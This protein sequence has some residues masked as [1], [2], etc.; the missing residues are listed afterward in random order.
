MKISYNWLLEYVDVKNSARAV[1]QWLTMAGLEVTSLE[2]KGK[3]SIL[4][5]EVTTN[6]PDWLSV[7][8]V[9]REVSAITGKR[10]KMPVVGNLTQAVRDKEIKVEVHDK[11]L[12]PR[13]TARIIDGVRVEPS[14]DWLRDRLQNIGVRPVNN[15]VDITNFVLF[16]MG[17]P[18][19]AFDYDK[20]AGQKVIVRRAQKGEAITTIDGVKREL[21]A[22]M[23]VIADEKGPVAV[24][25]V[26]GGLDTEVS[27]STKTIL[28][29]SACFDPISVRRAQK[30]LWLSSDSSYRFE[31]GVDL[32]GVL[33]A[34]NRA[35]GLTADI[36][37]GKIG[38]LKDIGTKVAKQNMVK[39]SIPR[40]NRILG[41]SLSPVA[42]KKIL[43]GLGLKVGAAQEELTVS[44]PSFRRDL[45]REEDLIEEIARIYGYDKIPT[46][47]PKTVGHLG[48]KEPA[49]KIQEAARAVLTG[50]GLDEIVTYSLVDKKDLENAGLLKSDTVFIKNPL[51]SQQEAMRPSLIPGALNA[52]RFNI[53]RKIEDFGIFELSNVY[54]KAKE[55]EYKEETDISILRLCPTA[56]FLEMKGIAE[57]LLERLG[58]HGCEFIADGSETVFY[59]GRSAKILVQGLEAGLI[60]E[61]KR[62]V[63]EKFDIKKD[64]FLCEIKLGR[65][66]DLVN[67]D[68]R[69]SGLPKFTSSKRDISLVAEKRAS[70]KELTDAAR[71]AAGDILKGISLI[72]EY[73][74]EQIP[75][76]KRG[77]TFSLEYCS[78]DKQ[79]TDDDIEQAHSRAKKALVE[80]F[81]AIIR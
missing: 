57:T 79:L 55:D 37:K 11:L 29:E 72:D 74:G 16:E 6:R 27:L 13:Y 26:M 36:A 69:F 48:L 4:E 47:I 53:N 50:Q 45:K 78:A 30:K 52:A 25:G 54:L 17:Q 8:G 15:I 80:K 9:A 75:K 34:S 7:L 42:A 41:T 76:G 1:A 51:S 67:K 44:A 21:D 28:L 58:I 56:N 12:C 60:G 39:V 71:E 73:Y 63:L 62:Q 32:E 49:R 3:D 31:R 2:E 19:H 70:I 33:F 23:L 22:D 43:T 18:L 10:I 59:N 40:T 38:P 61:V 20:L 46:T 65:L 81:G 14:P 77:L 35:A 5:L 64:I 24:A 66:Y 68:R